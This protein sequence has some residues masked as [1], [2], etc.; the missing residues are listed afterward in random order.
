MRSN[1]DLSNIA[2]GRAARQYQVSVE[3]KKSEGARG[4]C[5]DLDSVLGDDRSSPVTIGR[6]LTGFRD[7]EHSLI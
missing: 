1:D 3:P 5:A 2:E 4:I 6:W 7:D